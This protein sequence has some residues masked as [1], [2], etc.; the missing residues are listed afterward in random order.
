[1]SATEEEEINLKE[2]VVS[3]AKAWS[4]TKG[5]EFNLNEEVLNLQLTFANKILESVKE[6]RGILAFLNAPTGFGKTEAFVAPFLYSYLNDRKVFAPRMY[7][8]EPMHALLKQFSE[9]SQV[10]IKAL[11][12]N[13]LLDVGEDHGNVTSRTYLYTAPITLTTLDSYAY[14]FLA[15]RVETYKFSPGLITGRYSMPAGIQ[16]LSYT[17]LDEAH[18]IQDEAYVGPRIIRRIVASLVCSG[19][20]VVISSATLPDIL[21]NQI[22]N[23]VNEWC[24]DRYTLVE[25]ELDKAI[26]SIKASREIGIEYYGNQ[27]I[28]DAIKNNVKVV[29]EDRTLIIVNTIENAIRLYDE[30]RSACGGSTNVILLHSLMRTREK[31]NKFDQIKNSTKVHGKYVVIGT[32]VLEV[33]LDFNFNKLYTELAPIDAL[34]QRM[35]RICRD[36][37]KDCKVYIYKPR[38]SLPYEDDLISATENALNNHLQRHGGIN[39]FNTGTIQALVNNV[40]N[41]N[42]IEK[43]ETK[44][45]ELFLEFMDYMG[46]LHLLSYPPEEDVFIRPSFYVTLSLMSSKEFQ[47]EFQCSEQ[48]DECDAN[49]IKLKDYEFKVSIPLIKDQ[50]FA[51]A[52]LQGIIDK[53][54]KLK[55][56]IY[57]PRKLELDMIKLRKKSPEDVSHAGW[58]KGRY[59]VLVLEQSALSNMYDDKHGLRVDTLKYLEQQQ[60]PTTK[61]QPFTSKHKRKTGFGSRRTR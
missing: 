18:L 12:L 46:K 34:I 50:G 30:L 37:Q 49:I 44:G 41:K 16:S 14:G 52:R 2:V 28:E 27:S 42:I 23:E 6:E 43:L 4:Q 58:I 25:E 8:V 55:G 9:R 56:E 7:I 19:G 22:K 10:Y 61:T 60:A 21:R 3:A 59:I 32:Q 17:V 20:V 33:G 47:E 29:C 26:E 48:S 38:S 54:R 13:S 35:G 15:K 53:V 57:I 40:Y 11:Y 45:D 39:L 24:R 1:M 5:K 31:S 36:G 51:L